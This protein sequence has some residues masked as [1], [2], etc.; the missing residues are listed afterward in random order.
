MEKTFLITMTVL[1]DEDS[2][3]DNLTDRVKDAIGFS[4]AREALE[5]ALHATV[6]LEVEEVH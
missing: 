6:T 4:T 2:E 5:E 3:H 1:Q